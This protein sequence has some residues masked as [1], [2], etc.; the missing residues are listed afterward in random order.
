MPFNSFVITNHPGSTIAL[1]D[2]S[3]RLYMPKRP[4]TNMSTI[5]LSTLCRYEVTGEDGKCAK[6]SDLSVSLDEDYP[7][8]KSLSVWKDGQNL[9]LDW[10]DV[11][12]LD[13]DA[14][15]IL[16]EKKCETRSATHA[17]DEVLLKDEVLDALVIDLTERRAMRANDLRLD[18]E[19]GELRL[20][21]VDGSA[22]ALFHR[23]SRGVST[24]R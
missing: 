10:S 21:A 17:P 9:A 5:M 19:D 23:L 7:L 15:K 18:E 6:L 12:S 11:K 13:Y 16:V 24:L 1:L 14:K 20:S 2:Q 3:E 4:P 8:V 22:S